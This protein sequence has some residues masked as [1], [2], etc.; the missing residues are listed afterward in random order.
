MTNF[1]PIKFNLNL[2][3]EIILSKITQNFIYISAITKDYNYI[4]IRIDANQNP[5]NS[6]AFVHK[7]IQVEG[8]VLD[9]NESVS[10]QCCVINLAKCRYIWEFNKM[11]PTKINDKILN[12]NNPNFIPQFY[13]RLQNGV[14]IDKNGNLY[15][16]NESSQP[17]DSINT[18]PTGVLITYTSNITLISSKDK[19]FTWNGISIQKIFDVN[20]KSNLE[21]YERENGPGRPFNLANGSYNT[22]N[23]PTFYKKE[24]FLPTESCLYERHGSIIW[25]TSEGIYFLDAETLKN[26]EKY[27][28]DD[29]YEKCGITS[30][31]KCDIRSVALTTYFMA[32]LFN[33][34]KIVIYCLL[35]NKIMSVIDVSGK[36]FDIATLMTSDYYFNTK[37]DIEPIETMSFWALTSKNLFIMFDGQKAAKL[38][39]RIA[40][41]MKDYGLAR[42]MLVGFLSEEEARLAQEKIDFNYAEELMSNENG[43]RQYS[44]AASYY[45][46]CE[47]LDLPYIIA[48]F[49]N[50]EDKLAGIESLLEFL[51]NKLAWSND[52]GEKKKLISTIVSL[53]ATSITSQYTVTNMSK[54]SEELINLREQRQD[55]SKFI[56]DGKIIEAI[57]HNGKDD[58]QTVHK[59]YK[60]LKRIGDPELLITTA[61]AL[62][63]NHTLIESMMENKFFTEVLDEFENM[64]LSADKVFLLKKYILVL[65]KCTWLDRKLVLH[66]II[67][68]IEYLDLEKI[69]FDIADT[70]SY[71]D[72]NLVHVLN[73]LNTINKQNF[74]NRLNNKYREIVEYNLLKLQVH[75]FSSTDL[76]TVLYNKIF[77]KDILSSQTAVIGKSGVND[78]G[79]QNIQNHFY[80]LAE[81]IDKNHSEKC[82]I[83]LRCLY[84]NYQ[85]SLDMIRKEY[86]LGIKILKNEEF[87]EEQSLYNWLNLA[88]KAINLI[89]Q[90]QPYDHNEI[91]KILTL[92]IKES[93]TNSSSGGQ[94][95]TVQD[96]LPLI[97]NVSDNLKNEL[98]KDLELHSNEIGQRKLL[99]AEN[100]RFL[101]EITEKLKNMNTVQAIGNSFSDTNNTRTK[102]IRNS[103]TSAITFPT[104]SKFMSISQLKEEVQFLYSDRRD[105]SLLLKDCPI[106]GRIAATSV[107]FALEVEDDE[108]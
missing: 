62:T 107:A 99:I 100:G 56:N 85:E 35:N 65:Y 34:R 28:F 42:Q 77:H 1:K 38:L 61:K 54:D 102:R 60:N 18:A 30:A 52:L 3:P 94:L 40:L 91:I 98:V 17:L 63:D 89:K 41:N 37:S 23:A 45:S 88:K 32:V 57:K 108:F 36:E 80:R 49:L 71:S 78:A 13:R 27:N 95:L 76:E 16:Y 7:H 83:L 33:N 24:T 69:L 66:L 74:N 26:L 90:K 55:F 4:L 105:P 14:V 20:F 59:I 67:D 96:F 103:Q 53:Y 101:A 21:S 92:F 43:L 12:K 106:Y 87:F 22:E 8:E 5:S 51:K 48:K 97:E 31:H 58:D 19:L 70:K 46:K 10:E 9:F 93:G 82:Q 81:F 2:T 6:I 44:K 75:L 86:T 104:G 73:F 79:S 29:F 11:T 68:N 15:N 47:N 84:K 25:N 72:E 64:P 50:V 39:W